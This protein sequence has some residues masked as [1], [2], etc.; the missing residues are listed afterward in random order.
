MYKA[1]WHD[2]V[3]C[4]K[5]IFDDRSDTM[6]AV[7][8]EKLFFKEFGSE[9]KLM[10]TLR[11]PNIVMFMGVIIESDFVGLVTEFCV[12]G[13]VT[14][15]LMSGTGSDAISA[16][17]KLRMM[18]DT[19]RGMSFLH[20]HRPAIIHRDLKSANILVD[21]NLHCK[22]SDFGLSGLR[23]L[24]VAPDDSS[25]SAKA[26][27][28]FWAAPEILTGGKTAN[29]ASDVYSY[30]V[31]IF[32]FL[33]LELPYNT[34]EV[35]SIP[36]MVSAGKRPDRYASDLAQSRVMGM[37]RRLLPVM[38]LMVDCW[39]ENPLH[40]PTFHDILELMERESAAFEEDGKIQRAIKP[41]ESKRRTSLTSDIDLGK[42]H[43]D[44]K[45]ITKGKRLGTGTFGQVFEASYL[46]TSV[47]VKELFSNKLSNELILEFHRECNLMR[48]MRHP[49]IVL[50]MGSAS[51]PPKLFMVLELCE[52]GSVMNVYNNTPKPTPP[53]IHDRKTLGLAYGIVSGG[54]YLHMHTPVIIH[55]D[56]KSENILIDKN[57]VPKITDFGQSRF[58]DNTRTMTSGGSPLWT[59][60]EVIRGEKYSE[61]ADVFSFAIIL[62]EIMNWKMPYA[63]IAGHAVM[64]KVAAQNLRPPIEE[65]DNPFLVSLAKRCW[66]N[67]PRKRPGF[68]QIIDEIDKSETL[69]PLLGDWVP[70]SKELL[71][72]G[73]P[74]MMHTA[75]PMNER[76]FLDANAR[77]R[78][79][80][81]QQHN[82]LGVVGEE[83]HIKPQKFTESIGARAK[84][85][86]V[87]HGGAGGSEPRS[88]ILHIGAEHL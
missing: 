27:S 24:S 44:C 50:F 31:V 7:K 67:D 69:R 79:T 41:S 19:A 13:N 46:G 33:Y 87:Q 55:R 65:T 2:T 59:A 81:R 74:V 45:D 30:G 76:S 85:V 18:M 66:D 68:R 17:I 51:D 40:R 64:M 37:D 26:G 23:S 71:P 80:L 88:S 39:A 29:E 62:W 73:S 57:W 8:D 49:N 78:S 43:L 52:L 28:L 54:A 22:V 16:G 86:S 14:D 20:F 42:F 70:A 48:D 5:Q 61:K 60:P 58:K 38:K 63:G 15:V 77:R 3:V 25:N 9:A 36:F 10:S 35:A 12:E 82:P 83:G 84:R 6:T 72:P 1:T 34:L 75:S 11:H 21:D 47:A 4:V 32:E 56:L 53:S